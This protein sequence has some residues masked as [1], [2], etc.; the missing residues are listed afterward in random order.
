MTT[1]EAEDLIG[2]PLFINVFGEGRTDK[3]QE[4]FKFVDHYNKLSHPTRVKIC[5]ILNGYGSSLEGKKKDFI[6]SSSPFRSLI[7]VASTDFIKIITIDKIQEIYDLG[8]EDAAF[9]HDNLL[10]LMLTRL[11]EYFNLTDEE[12]PF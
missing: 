6:F 1:D 5:K 2:F 4:C 9:V 7:Y 8:D 11:N 10:K 3:G 12:L